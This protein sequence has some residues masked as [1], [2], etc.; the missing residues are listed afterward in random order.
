MNTGDRVRL[1]APIG[2]YDAGCEGFVQYVGSDGLVIVIA[3][4]YENGQQINPPMPLPPSFAS[5]F[6]VLD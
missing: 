4:M 3:D 5:K 6:E 1:V 2:V